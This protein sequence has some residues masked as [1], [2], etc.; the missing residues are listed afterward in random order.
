V[1][2]RRLEPRG[3]PR[4]AAVHGTAVGGAF[5]FKLACLHRVVS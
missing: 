4:V 2:Y 5:E 1:I 3:K